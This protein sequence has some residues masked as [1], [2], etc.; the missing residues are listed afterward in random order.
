MGLNARKA[1][2]LGEGASARD[3]ALGPDLVLAVFLSSC[4][5]GPGKVLAV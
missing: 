4:V 3:R 5:L 2:L 1:G